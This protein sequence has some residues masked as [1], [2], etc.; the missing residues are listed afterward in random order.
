MTD[1]SF[2]ESR[3]G[4][5][6]YSAKEAFEFVTDIRNFERFIQK[7]TINNWKAEKEFCS[8]SVSMLGTVALRIA[9]KEEFKRVVYNGDALKKNDFILALSMIDNI[10]NKADVSIVLS[11]DLN[12]M[13]KV[14]A[15]KPIEQFLERLIYE[16]EQFRGW[17]DVRL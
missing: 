2:F 9:E 14:M 8:F 12:P 10:N 13:M 15:A 4:T 16:M 17:N 6:S 5:L 7:G 11:A 1:L 3:H